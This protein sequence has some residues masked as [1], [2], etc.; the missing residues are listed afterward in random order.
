MHLQGNVLGLDFGERTGYAVLSPKGNLVAC[1]HID[2]K[3]KPLP[4]RLRDLNVFLRNV[5][6]LHDIELFTY[7]HIAFLRGKDAYEMQVAKRSLVKLFAVLSRKPWYGVNNQ[8]IKILA[9]GKASWKKE[10]L[11]SKQVQQLVADSALRKWGER[12][13]HD[14]AHAVFCAEYA[15]V[16]FENTGYNMKDSHE[17]ILPGVLSQM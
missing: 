7:E 6:Q 8:H 3:G 11:T 4:I 2:M 1:D 13:N 17:A 5:T 9:T 14:V 16:K 15:R 12:I 10:G